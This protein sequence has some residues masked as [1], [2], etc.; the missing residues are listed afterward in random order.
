MWVLFN[1][2]YDEG[3]PLKVK[4]IFQSWP[5]LKSLPD[6]WHG[7]S[8]SPFF[9]LLYIFYQSIVDLQCLR[10]GITLLKTLETILRAKCLVKVYIYAHSTHFIFAIVNYE[11]MN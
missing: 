10:F 11:I 5:L 1:I 3:Q 2:F 6:H 9:S 4:V 7:P 8:K